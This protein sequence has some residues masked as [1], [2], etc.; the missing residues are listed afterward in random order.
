MQQILDALVNGLVMVVVAVIGYVG[1]EVRKLVVQKISELVSRQEKNNVLMAQNLAVIA[2]QAVE[3]MFKEI[4]GEAKLK[5]A[6]GIL[7][8]SLDNHGLKLSD[9][10]METLVE[11]AVH[12]MNEFKVSVTDAIT[13]PLGE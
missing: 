5:E 9:A 1:L 7:K 4:K 11:S 10:Q 8:V 3:Q 6:I 12:E 2:V 13:K